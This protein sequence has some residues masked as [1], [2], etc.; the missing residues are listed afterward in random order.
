MTSHFFRWDAMRQVALRA[1]L[2]HA[3]T[4]PFYAAL[5]SRDARDRALAGASSAA[6]LAE[7]MD[8][9]PILSKQQLVNEL[10]VKLLDDEDY[11]ISVSHSTG[12]TGLETYRYRTRREVDCIAKF[13]NVVKPDHGPKIRTRSQRLILAPPYQGNSHEARA[14]LPSNFHDI[15][16]AIYD[17]VL[18]RQAR[19]IL[20]REFEIPGFSSRVMAVAGYVRHVVVL[21]Q[22]L[23]DDNFGRSAHGVKLV[24]VYGGVLAARE[25]KLLKD[26]WGV[27]PINVYSMSEVAGTHFICPK[28]GYIELG[29]RVYPQVLDCRAEK[30][31]QCGVGRLCLT[32]LYPFGMSQPL[33]K[34]DTQDLVEFI[35][36]GAACAGHKGGIRPLGRSYCSA[37]DADGLPII[38]SF[39]LY[40]ALVSSGIVALGGDVPVLAALRNRDSVGRPYARVHF[41]EQTVG[42]P[43][44]IKVNFRPRESY[45]GDAAAELR[46]TLISAIAPLARALATG[47]IALS[48]HADP[49]LSETL[50]W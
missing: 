8:E 17:D 38:G 37:I 43:P 5:W 24:S 15:H 4:H 46:A 3:A 42:G 26:F 40:D 18:V 11:V 44:S 12:T 1:T 21:T 33:V 14:L 50:G 16:C 13:L 34:Y 20:E 32:E 9:L 30:S 31:V 2:Q 45:E 7:L 25:R 35:P 41:N 6:A 27:E 10:R 39:Q 22:C 48:V 29:D 19:H 36:D 28:C 23:I 47:R 49:F